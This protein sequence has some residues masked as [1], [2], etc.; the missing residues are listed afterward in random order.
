MRH[1]RFVP[2]FV[3]LAIVAAQLFT[4]TAKAEPA[5]GKD[6]RKLHVMNNCSDEQCFYTEIPKGWHAPKEKPNPAQ[7]RQVYYLAD[8][9]SNQKKLSVVSITPTDQEK[10]DFK[11]KMHQQCEAQSARYGWDKKT[12]LNNR[13]ELKQTMYAICTPSIK[14]CDKFECLKDCYEPYPTKPPARNAKK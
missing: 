6:M 11:E 13:Q 12:C 2:V 10:S 5:V 7:V 1:K 4:G 3:V 8:D 14:G 9:R